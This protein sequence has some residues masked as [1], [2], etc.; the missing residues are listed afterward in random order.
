MAVLPQPI[1]DFHVHLFPDRLF[2]AIWKHFADDYGWDVIYHLYYREC[3]AHL[4]GNGVG[5][6]AYSNY[7]HRKGM[8]KS[9]NEWNLRVLDE[10]PDL[11]C[12]AAYHP[13][14][15]DGPDMA[16]TIIEHPRILG[17]KLQLL[18]QGFYPHDERLYPLYDLITKAG[19]R[20]LVHT[21][22]GPIGNEFTGITHF[23]KLLKQYPDMKITVPHM[24]AMEYDEFGRLLDDYP[25]L[26]FDTAY[27]FIPQMAEGFLT[28]GLGI[29]FLE[30]YRD[31]IL[32]GSDF[33]NVLYPR[34]VEIQALLDLNLSQSFYNKVF[35][36]NA[37]GIIFE[38]Q[39]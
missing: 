6:V 21:G 31:R 16:A 18:V 38:T 20:L 35:R 13:E 17:F 7:A 5:A 27:T 34:E 26:Y 8:A 33:P 4:R 10:I 25:N 14:D 1:I 2:D 39:R 19:K 28:S 32:Y 9:L 11:Y 22:T 30:K 3:I 23:K 37:L 36:D 24:G 12:F 15:E 29:D